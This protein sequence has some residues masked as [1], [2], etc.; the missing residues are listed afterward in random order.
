MLIL[1]YCICIKWTKAKDV[2]Q[3]VLVAKVSLWSLNC[4]PYPIFLEFGCPQ[5]DTDGRGVS[6]EKSQMK[7]AYKIFKVGKNTVSGVFEGG[8]LKFF[9]GALAITSALM[10]T[11]AAATPAVFSMLILQ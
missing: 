4:S 1:D 10:P 2:T 9:G 3:S 11:F 5:Y 6:S 8:Q 7:Q